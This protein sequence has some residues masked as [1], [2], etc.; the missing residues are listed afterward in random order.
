MRFAANYFCKISQ[1]YLEFIIFWY[2]LADDTLIKLLFLFFRKQILTFHTNCLHLRQIAWNV[3]ACFLRKIYLS[4][5]DSTQRVKRVNLDYSVYLYVWEAFVIQIEP[6]CAFGSIVQ[7]QAMVYKRQNFH[8]VVVQLIIIDQWNQTARMYEI[9][10]K[11]IYSR[12]IL[13]SVTSE[14][15]SGST[16]FA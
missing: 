6:F 11:V 12:V 2:N 5:S 7:Y 1:L 15:C 9:Q 16:L 13:V 10:V 4:S 8:K 3:R 14:C